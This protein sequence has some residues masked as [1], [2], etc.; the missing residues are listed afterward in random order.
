MGGG[1]ANSC[2]L[3]EAFDIVERLTGRKIRY[4]YVEQPRSGDQICYITNF[5]RFQTHYRNWSVTNPL[6]EL[7]HD[8]VEAWTV[9]L[10]G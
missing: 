8:I 3:L 5:A 10:L 9:R 1:R 7:F 2:S 4:E 6:D